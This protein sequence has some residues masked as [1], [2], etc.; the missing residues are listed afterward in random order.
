MITICGV[1]GLGK[2][3]LAIELARRLRYGSGPL[4]FDEVYWVPLAAFS[5]PETVPELL[6]SGL[7]IAS[8]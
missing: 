2:T 7:G 8:V 4:E 6:A 3:R 5:D 1:G